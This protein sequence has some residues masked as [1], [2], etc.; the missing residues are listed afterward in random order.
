MASPPQLALFDAFVAMDDCARQTLSALPTV[1]NT[2]CSVRRLALFSSLWR[3]ICDL[4][5][6]RT[7]QLLALKAELDLLVY[8]QTKGAVKRLVESGPSG[9]KKLDG[10]GPS[11]VKKLDGSGPS[12]VK[13]LAGGGPSG[14]RRSRPGNF[15]PGSDV[16]PKYLSKQTVDDVKRDWDEAMGSSCGQRGS[17]DSASSLP[18][19]APAPSLIRTTTLP[20]F[21]DC[22]AR[23]IKLVAEKSVAKSG[24]L[25]RLFEE[26]TRVLGRILSHQTAMVHRQRARARSILRRNKELGMELARTSKLVHAEKTE[27]IEFQLNKQRENAMLLKHLEDKQ[28]DRE[29]KCNEL[30]ESLNVATRMCNVFESRKKH[31]VAQGA[32]EKTYKALQS[33]RLLE[34]VA[35]GIQGSAAEKV[36]MKQ[37]QKDVESQNQLLGE[38]NHLLQGI[39]V[40]MAESLRNGIRCDLQVRRPVACQTDL[41]EAGGEFNLR[42]DADQKWT[43]VKKGGEGWVIRK[44]ER[45]GSAPYL[46]ALTRSHLTTGYESYK[47]QQLP[48]HRTMSDLYNILGV[49]IGAPKNLTINAVFYGVFLGRYQMA[50]V[51]EPRFVDFAYSL[52]QFSQSH[53]ESAYFRIRVVSELL[54]ATAVDIPTAQEA[55]LEYI[56]VFQGLRRA[57]PAREFFVDAAGIAYVFVPVALRYL[58]GYN[59]RLTERAL[60]AM[61]KPIVL[62]RASVSAQGMVANRAMKQTNPEIELVDVVNADTVLA[63]LV[64]GTLD[65]RTITRRRLEILF[66]ASD[67][68]SDGD[69]SFKEFKI[70]LNSIDPLL[71]RERAGGMFRDCSGGRGGGGDGIADGDRV[72]RKDFVRVVLASGVYSSSAIRRLRASKCGMVQYGP[73][74]LLSGDDV[75]ASVKMLSD[76]WSKH[77]ADLKDLLEYLEKT[78][79]TPGD[80][81]HVMDNKKRL[82]HFR[83]AYRKA[84]AGSHE[85]ALAWTIY[86]IMYYQ[87]HLLKK[88]RTKLMQSMGPLLG[89]LRFKRKL[90]GRIRAPDRK[91]MGKVNKSAKTIVFDHCRRNNYDELVDAIEAGFN[92]DAIDSKGNTLLHVAAQNGHTDIV[93]L[94]CDLG[95]TVGARNLSGITAIDCARRYNYG[96]LVKLLEEAQEEEEEDGG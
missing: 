42:N 7:G 86:R 10:S 56:R 39:R 52:F 27:G 1:G 95:C 12:G 15:R 40:D 63:L 28:R 29:S 23:L 91:K 79:K 8:H 65:E 43:N 58:E 16:A 80:A 71:P 36:A 54:N 33:A 70:V 50:H 62:S 38:I 75:T 13:K 17:S 59:S 68:D 35:S 14:A 73:A 72:L 89:V 3:Q 22:L 41:D 6:G 69:L 77:K 81:W 93:A 30:N 87:I 82:S 84:N 4:P 24:L 94:L 90:L 57:M 88:G 20:K 83:R 11:G 32:R 21:H 66:D 74:K 92:M 2:K 55:F 51:A 78:S 31:R 48:L 5:L 85:I 34:L 25:Q 67:F 96:R 19:V 64:Q 9:L 26:G 60:D 49:V 37:R 47:P 76:E 53:R 18:R 61:K 45:K 44:I 46:S